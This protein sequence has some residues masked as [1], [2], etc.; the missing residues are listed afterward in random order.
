MM[1]DL[2]FSNIKIWSIV[3]AVELTGK[4]AEYDLM[5]SIFVQTCGG[6]ASLAIAWSHIQ[7]GRKK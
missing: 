3:G 7:K 6:L 5:T 1:N 2:I 4:L